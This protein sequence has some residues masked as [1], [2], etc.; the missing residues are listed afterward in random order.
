MTTSC[1]NLV[2]TKLPETRRAAMSANSDEILQQV[3]QEFEAILTFV[4]EASPKTVP[5][6]DTMERGLFRK[7][8]A[9]GRLL[10]QLYFRQQDR[11][12]A[13]ESVAGKEQTQ[14]PL[15]SRKQ[16]TYLSIFG[17]VTFDR[18]YYYLPG[19]GRYPLDAT[20]NLPK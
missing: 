4:L 14:L 12:I 7:L 9:I 13:P 5:D 1:G 19:E 3:R 18:R 20:L 17:Q 16:R 6:A 8:F 2:A 10:L 15:H 11:L